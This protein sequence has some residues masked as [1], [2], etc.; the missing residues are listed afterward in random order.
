MKR[1]MVFIAWLVWSICAFE[2]LAQD[3]VITRTDPVT[4]DVV[5]SNGATTITIRP[6]EPEPDP[7]P[8]LVPG[9]VI[10]AAWIKSRGPAPWYLDEPG[11]TYTV[12]DPLP[13]APG[14]AFVVIAPDV[15][16]DLGGHLVAYGSVPELENWSFEN[17]G[18]WFG[19]FMPVVGDYGK[20]EI[21]H[22]LRAQ[23]FT[24]PGQIENIQT[25]TVPANTSVCFSALYYWQSGTGIARVELETAGETYSA[26]FNDSTP[27]G[28]GYA[29]AV[30][31][32]SPVERTFTARVVVDSIA[33][34]LRVD[35]ANVSAYRAAGVFAGPQKW[36]AGVCPGVER[37]AGA[38]RCTIKNGRFESVNSGF[39]CY[40]FRQTRSATTRLENVV[41]HVGGVNSPAYA[42]ANDA[43]VSGC[44]I[45]SDVYHTTNRNRMD[46]AYMGVGGGTITGNTFRGG[47]HGGIYAKSSTLVADNTFSTETR[48]TNGFAI[49]AGGEITRNKIENNTDIW[50]GRGVAPF[51]GAHVHDND[52]FCRAL[53]RNQEYR[54]FILGGCY[55]IQVEQQS[56]VRINNNRVRVWALNGGQSAALRIGG[57]GGGSFG[58]EI[59][60]N[61]FAAMSDGQPGSFA[62]CLKITDGLT[63]DHAEFRDN[64]WK[65][66]DAFALA[67]G[68]RPGDDKVSATFVNSTIVCPDPLEWGGVVHTFEGGFDRD[69]DKNYA[70]LTFHNPGGNVEILSNP[71]LIE[72]R[73]GFGRPEPRGT[74]IIE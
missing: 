11:A 12:V 2:V 74:V 10:N 19:D 28:F 6:G 30:V 3:T 14:T 68:G 53:P 44:K 7:P 8:K 40:G 13:S 62:R 31:P 64:I 50:S 29:S 49:M 32:V 27:K 4:V 36:A 23:E 70:E 69:R 41:Y 71:Y 51:T 56:L 58:L 15:T 47:C 54:G 1:Q 20:R 63:V 33:G 66:N 25:V 55:G 5:E 67:Y 16:L 73:Y 17:D 48:F 9:T 59:Y 60:E 38:D 65:T 21:G 43:T 52:I 39:E 35:A 18:G 37:F 45:E 72:R 26:Q 24:D 46:W 61:K 57:S 34:N 42:I 22:G